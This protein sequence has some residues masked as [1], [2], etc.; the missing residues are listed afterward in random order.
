M[1][2]RVNRINVLGILTAT[3][4]AILASAAGARAQSVTINSC[5]AA[6]VKCIAKS[7]K[8]RLACQAKAQLKGDTPDAY[9]LQEAVDKFEACIARAD[10]KPPCLTRGD[11]ANLEGKIDD[12]MIDVVQSL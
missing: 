12:F 5:A 7:V 3:S 4:L 11:T 1:R 2:A 8:N 9:C 10:S 6:K